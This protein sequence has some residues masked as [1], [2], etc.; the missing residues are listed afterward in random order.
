M[1][2][3]LDCWNSFTSH[4]SGRMHAWIEEALSGWLLDQEIVLANR[5]I[6]NNSNLGGFLSLDL[7]STQEIDYPNIQS[8]DSVD[9]VIGEFYTVSTLDQHVG[10][11]THLRWDSP[12]EYR[13]SK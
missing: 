2:Y 10:D 9:V 3:G 11:F 7:L 5:D 13:L 1:G 6:N 12:Q 8:L 4:Q